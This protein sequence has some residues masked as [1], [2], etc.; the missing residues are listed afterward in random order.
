MSSDPSDFKPTKNIESPAS[1]SS[2]VQAKSLESES[3]AAFCRAQGKSVEFQTPTVPVSKNKPSKAKPK[4]AAKNLSQDVASR[5]RSRREIKRKKFDDEIVDTAPV[6]APPGFTNPLLHSAGTSSR[7]TLPSPA[8]ATSTFV[9]NLTPSPSSTATMS[10]LHSPDT[11]LARPSSSFNF[12]P[13]SSSSNF[14]RQ[15][16]SLGKGKSLR[17]RTSSVAA[18]L[19]RK[20]KEKNKKKQRKDGAWKGLGRWKPTDDLAL[21]TAAMQV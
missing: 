1:S 11:P 16:K 18:E 19:E 5:P 8:A 21:I 3:V 9:P 12:T 20:R 6:V 14:G 7:T 2:S 15:G 13:S 17:S 10:S 4:P